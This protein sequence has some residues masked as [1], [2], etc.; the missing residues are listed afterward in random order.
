MKEENNGA[1]KNKW[2]RIFRKKWF[3]PAV[4]LTIAAL[5]LTAVVWYQNV[6]QVP[7]AT[8]DEQQEQ[9][10]D[11]YVP[12]PADEEAE[13]VLDQQE[14]IQTPVA[15][16]DQAEIVT[17]FYDYNADQADQEDALVHYNNRYYQSTGVDIAASG[18][19]TFDVLASLSGTVAEVK[20]DPLLG[21]VV[22]LEHGNEVSTYYASLGEVNVEAGQEVEQGATIGTAGNNLFGKD[23][24]THVHFQLRKSGE[25]VNPTE[26][27]NQPVSSLTSAAAESENVDAGESEG[28][29]TEENMDEPTAPAESGEENPDAPATPGDSEGEN[30]EAPTEPG[31]SDEE[32]P[33]TPTSPGNSDEETPEAPEDEGTDSEDGTEDESAA[34]SGNA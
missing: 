30:P 13:P 2:S 17:K 15:D 23:E 1:S 34:S 33:E 5:L 19:E 6:E 12:T 26:Y 4:Y 20:E 16:E 27:F 24:G 18:G 3:F 9:T 21:N 8:D 10:T 29:E 31:E 14:V 22:V 7:D 32:N 28:T 25:E 11:E